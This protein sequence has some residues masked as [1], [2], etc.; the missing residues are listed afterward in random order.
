[1][2]WAS[3]QT[4]AIVASLFGVALLA[5]LA[6]AIYKEVLPRFLP[7]VNFLGELGLRTSYTAQFANGQQVEAYLTERHHLV[8]D[9]EGW[10]P[11]RVDR[12]LPESGEYVVLKG[13]IS[14]CVLVKNVRALDTE[15]A[16]VEA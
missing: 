6:L 9:P 8:G 10:Y 13:A 16:A 12:Y 15:P 5:L 7:L 3:P 4:G 2:A 14:C 1:M 11:C